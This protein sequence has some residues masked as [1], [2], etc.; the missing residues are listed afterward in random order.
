MSG[1]HKN[2][3][4]PGPPTRRARGNCFLLAEFW[5]KFWQQL[6]TLA[7]G[8]TAYAASAVE[9]GVVLLK[10]VRFCFS[11]EFWFFCGI[12]NQIANYIILR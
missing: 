12:L 4:L 1:H 6:L 8:Q 3:L 9:E 10:V 11:T 5:L 2:L 7:R